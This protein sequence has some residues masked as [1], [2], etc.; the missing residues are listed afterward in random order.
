[1]K[2]NCDNNISRQQKNNY[3]DDNHRETKATTSIEE[4]N[5]FFFGNGEEEDN[6]ITKYIKNKA[7]RQQSNIFK[8]LEDQKLMIVFIYNSFK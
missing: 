3:L 7:K 2:L 5:S 6:S 4:D 1:M 8:D